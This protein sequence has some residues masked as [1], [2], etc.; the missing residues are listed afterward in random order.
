M[1][2]LLSAHK[3]VGVIDEILFYFSGLILKFTI[4]I[5]NVPHDWDEC[6]SQWMLFLSKKCLNE[7]NLDN[8]I[9]Y[10]FY[11]TL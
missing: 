1:N 4:Y 8:H 5:S 7:L 10:T 3:F 6:I 11:A 2:H 9:L